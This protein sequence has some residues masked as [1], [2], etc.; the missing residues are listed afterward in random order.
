MLNLRFG[1]WDGSR[2]GKVVERTMIVS[3][4]SFRNHPSVYAI[5][6]R[7]KLVVCRLGGLRLGFVL[8]CENF[9]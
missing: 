6:L 4:V 8:R 9:F 3:L 2:V 1:I 7:D 5:L